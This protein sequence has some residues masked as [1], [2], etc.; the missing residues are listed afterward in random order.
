[1]LQ[2]CAHFTDK[3]W[4]A[5]SDEEIVEDTMTELARIFPRENGESGSGRFH[6]E[7]WGA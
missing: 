4:I 7:I 5:A 6:P 3:N 1:M 2:R